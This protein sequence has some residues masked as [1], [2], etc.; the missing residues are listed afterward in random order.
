MTYLAENNKFWKSHWINGGIKYLSSNKNAH[1]GYHDQ[2][3]K[4]SIKSALKPMNSMYTKLGLSSTEFVYIS[5]RTAVR[6]DVN[7]LRFLK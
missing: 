3:F 2:A 1:I 6:L 7:T 4:G 5:L